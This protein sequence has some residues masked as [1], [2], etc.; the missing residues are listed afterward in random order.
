MNGG[1]GMAI[2][3]ARRYGIPVLNLGSLHPRAACERLE[4]IRA[5]AST[6]APSG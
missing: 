2:R 5:A 1:T 3:I 4:E 6:T